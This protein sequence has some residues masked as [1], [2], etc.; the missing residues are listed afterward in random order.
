MVNES[1]SRLLSGSAHHVITGCRMTGFRTMCL[2]IQCSTEPNFIHTPVLFSQHSIL[3][4]SRDRVPAA[5]QG[6]AR[7][8]G[9]WTTR[10]AS[11]VAAVIRGQAAERPD[12][13]LPSRLGPRAGPSRVRPRSRG[14]TRLP[15]P[16]IRIRP[17]VRPPAVDARRPRHPLI[18][19]CNTVRLQNGRIQTRARQPVLHSHSYHG[20][21]LLSDPHAHR[22]RAVRVRNGIR[23]SSESAPCAAARHPCDLARTPSA[24]RSGPSSP[25]AAAAAARRIICSWRRGA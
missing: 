7:A 23:R 12:P 1:E 18:P 6:A 14:R 10:Q 16:T 15:A 5:A 11:C 8:A 9:A 3:R 21:Y 24:P 2:G 20:I 25:A 17:A 13:R 22:S 4:Q 19:S